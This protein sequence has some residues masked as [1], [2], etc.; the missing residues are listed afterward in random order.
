MDRLE[1]EKLYE[2]SQEGR[3]SLPV[4]N[5]HLAFLTDTHHVEFVTSKRGKCGVFLPAR[6]QRHTF[7]F[8]CTV[9]RNSLLSPASAF[10]HLSLH[11]DFFHFM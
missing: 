1:E 9:D 4:S 3:S 6:E 11:F 10:S 8:I 5:L 2:R 7:V